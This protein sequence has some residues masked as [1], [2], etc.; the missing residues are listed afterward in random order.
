MIMIGVEIEMFTALFSV[1]FSK[2]SVW[3]VFLLS[4]SDFRFWFFSFLGGFFTR[5]LLTVKYKYIKT[6]LLFTCK[7]ISWRMWINLN[8]FVWSGLG[9][10]LVVEW[11][12]GVKNGLGNLLWVWVTEP[13]YTDWIFNCYSF[14]N[15]YFFWM[16]CV[17]IELYSLMIY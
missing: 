6:F 8:F 13:S 1:R 17:C 11:G 3:G 2:T 5:D 4:M 14:T 10:G 12:G 15:N 9:L 7:N 16:K